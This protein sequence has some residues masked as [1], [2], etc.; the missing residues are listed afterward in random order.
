MWKRNATLP[1][2]LHIDFFSNI[3]ERVTPYRVE[4]SVF[5]DLMRTRGLADVVRIYILPA[6]DMG[7]EGKI[8]NS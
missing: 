4:L 3:Y 2:T 8:K 5:N 6:I 7:L 1:N